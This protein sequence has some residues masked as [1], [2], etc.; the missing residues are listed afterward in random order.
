METYM[1]DI[2]MGGSIGNIGL[3]QGV[4]KLMQ[5]TIELSLNIPIVENITGGEPLY[6]KFM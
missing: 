4:H 5:S 6:M 1:K 2:N 3:H